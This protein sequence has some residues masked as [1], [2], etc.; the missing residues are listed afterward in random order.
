MKQAAPF[1]PKYKYDANEYTSSH[2]PSSDMDYKEEKG[3]NRPTSFS[4]K[5]NRNAWKGSSQ[6]LDLATTQFPQISDKLL[7]HIYKVDSDI[8]QR[9]KQQRQEGLHKT[10]KKIEMYQKLLQLKEAEEK[11]SKKNKGK[12]EVNKEKS[13]EEDNLGAALAKLIMNAG[14][15]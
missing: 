2:D 7:S 6:V 4:P 11:A 8:V 9:R 15:K 3:E 10:K 13:K 1:L 14:K 12:T 5:S